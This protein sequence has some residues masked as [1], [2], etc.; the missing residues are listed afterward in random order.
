[1]YMRNY[2][3]SIDGKFDKKLN[4]AV[5]WPALATTKLKAAK[6]QKFLLAYNL[7]PYQTTKFKFFQLY[8]IKIHP[9]YFSFHCC[10]CVISYSSGG[11]TILSC[12]LWS[13]KQF[14]FVNVLTM[15]HVEIHMNDYCHDFAHNIIMKVRC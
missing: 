6:S 4:L 9:S 1:M 10:C 13:A 5:W 7:M 12:M 15:E 2:C 14:K 11:H 8:G 3:Y